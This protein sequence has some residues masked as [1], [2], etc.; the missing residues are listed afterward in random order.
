MSRSRK[1]QTYA[2]LLHKHPSK[3]ACTVTINMP[4]VHSFAYSEFCHNVNHISESSK[5]V[6]KR[7]LKEE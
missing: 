3:F 1:L 6:Q 7:R 4:Y 2:K 5:G